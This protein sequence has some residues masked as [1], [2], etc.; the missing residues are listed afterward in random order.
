MPPSDTLREFRQQRFTEPLVRAIRERL[1][2]RTVTL[3]EVCGTHTVAIHKCGIRSLLPPTLKILSGPGCPVCVTP[4]HTIDTA[5]ALSRQPQNIIATFGDMMKVPGS[6]SSLLREK[7][8]AADVR[9]VFSPMDA[10][11]IAQDNPHRKIIFLAIG[12]ETT[13]PAIAAAVEEA[14]RRDL[15]NFYLLCAN[16][17]LPPAL[18]AIASSPELK[19][20]GLICPGHVSVITGTKIYDFLARDFHIPCVIAGFEPVDVLRA[21]LAL[22]QMV[23]AGEAR[24]VNKYE[25]VVSQEGNPIAQ[26]LMHKIFEETDSVW[27]G[28]GTIAKSGLTLRE[29]FAA[30]DAEKEIPVEV[31]ETREH[32]ECICGDVLRGVKTPP[33]CA[34]FRR[35]CTLENP[36]GA[37]M[38]SSEGNCAAYYKYSME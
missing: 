28:M 2:D 16:K 10:L 9:V 21:I 18:R 23:V 11:T 26:A 4:N 20:H 32:P 7:A 1:G 30:F 22:V 24:V 13:A 17:V 14:T 8:N 33:D 5:I 36:I 34:L 12:F 3:M 35:I 19:I 27:R 37:C 31:E 6:S 15:P 25:R 38:V 29:E